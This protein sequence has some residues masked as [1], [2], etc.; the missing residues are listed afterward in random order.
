[1]TANPFLHK[2]TWAYALFWSWNLIFL[3]FMLLGFA[4]TILPEMITAVRAGTIPYPY[5]ITASI[6]AAIPAFA[7]LI[8]LTA[9]RQ[10][11]GKLLL[12]GY[13]VEGPLMLILAFRTFIVRDATAVVNILLAIGA[14]GAL[15]LLWHLLDSRLDERGPLL[16][17]SRLIGLTLLL[18]LGLYASLWLAF[19]ALPASS[20]IAEAVQAFFRNFASFWRDLV[21]TWRDNVAMLPFLLIGGPLFLYSATLFVVMPLAVPLIYF[22][23]WRHSVQAL[24][25]R[26]G[27]F[28]PLAGATAVLVAAIIIIGQASR[29]PQQAAFA[30]L[31]TPPATVA[32]AEAL[33]AQEETIRAGLVNAYLA[34]QRYLSAA[35]EMNHVSEMYEYSLDFSPA[36]AA[37]VQSWYE[38]VAAPLLYQPVHTYNSPN[39][40]DNRTLR[41]EPQAAA[42]LYEQFFDEDILTGEREAIAQAARATWEP[43]QARANWQAVDEREVFLAQ[44]E[45]TITEHDDWAEV[46]LFEAYENQTAQRQEVIY[47][48]SLPES[49]VLTGVWLGNSPNRDERFAFRVAPRGAAQAVYQNEVRRRVDPALLEQIGPRQYRL[50]IFPIPPQSWRWDGEQNGSTLLVS[51]FTCG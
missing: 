4:P 8:G 49:A 11:P 13:G 34:P 35:G 31:E 27:R 10:Q 14:V 38:T 29:Q 50:R 22:Q 26:Y 36:Q 30:L 46:T 9:L 6:I 21:N 1:M 42:Q 23:T 24:T 19:Y 32:E 37:R 33:L 39:R 43:D 51:R 15:T 45:V 5:V 28:R 20:F 16:K 3:A 12:L 18:G 17:S 2:R 47:Y 40:W 7:V 25:P 48:F 44:Q 41:E